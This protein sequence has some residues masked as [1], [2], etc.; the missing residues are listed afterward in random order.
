PQGDV[1]AAQGAGK[2]RT[3]PVEGVAVDRLPVMDD[4]PRVLADQ[5]RL[6]LPDGRLHRLSTALDDGLAEADDVGVGVD[7]QKQPA[8]LN[9]ERF[10][11]GDP[12]RI[13]WPDG[14]ISV[15]SGR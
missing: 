2:D 6:D 11:P 13:A 15:L 5:V 4:L 8:R 3:A 7:L 14:S 9:K 1:D 12:Q 10:Q